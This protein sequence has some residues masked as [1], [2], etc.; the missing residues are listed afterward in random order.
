M[1]EGWRFGKVDEW[2]NAERGLD[3]QR[4]RVCG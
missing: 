4:M 3:K 1:W 2:V